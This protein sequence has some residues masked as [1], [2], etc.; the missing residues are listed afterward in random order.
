MSNNFK[1]GAKRM[2]CIRRLRLIPSALLKN[3]LTN[4]IG[5]D[6]ITIVMIR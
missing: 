1:T 6:T 2:A 4:S 5:F 3:P